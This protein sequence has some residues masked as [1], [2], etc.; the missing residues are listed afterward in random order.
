MMC[1]TGLMHTIAGALDQAILI[2]GIAS[3]NRALRQRLRTA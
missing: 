2:I 1:I 3:G